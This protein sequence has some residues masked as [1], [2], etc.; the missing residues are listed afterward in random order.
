MA[1]TLIRIAVAQVWL[2]QG[3]WSKLLGHQARHAAIVARI[4]RINEA[5]AHATLLAIGCLECLLAGWILS[6]RRAREAAFV[7]TAVL[8][9]MNG[10]GLLWAGPIIPDPVGMILQNFSFILLAW[11]AAGELGPYAK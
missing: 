7:Q 1:N 11:V 8:V 10:G 3:L 4:P 5:N 6:G 2:Y 9:M